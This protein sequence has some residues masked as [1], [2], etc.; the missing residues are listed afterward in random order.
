MA[1]DVKSILTEGLN[2]HN[3][4]LPSINIEVY[5]E[6]KSIAIGNGSGIK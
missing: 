2:K 4:P 1:N 3:I 6:D 5:K